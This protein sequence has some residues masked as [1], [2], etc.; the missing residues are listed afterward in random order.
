MTIPPAEAPVHA[1]WDDLPA[2]EPR[3]A[4][5]LDRDVEVCVVGAGLAGL[6][7]A[8]EAAR[9]GMSV[10]V[11]EGRRIGWA[12]SGCNLGSVLPGYGVPVND[13]IARVGVAHARELWM[14]AEAGGDYIRETIAQD[15]PEIAMVPG[16]LEVSTTDAGERLIRW[17]QIIGGEFG[18]EV[19]GWQIEHVREA[20]K[21]RRYFHALHFPRAFQ[22][23]SARYLRALAAL[24]EEA[25]AQI[26]EGTPVVSIDAAGIRKRI[27]T[28]SANLRA[29]HIVLAGNVH[30][31]TS[32]ERLATT[33]MPVWRYG[34]MTEPL[35]DLLHEAITYQG[36][37]HDDDGIDHFRVVGDRLLWASPETTWENK[38]ERFARAIR[39]RIATV[40]PQLAGVAIARTFASPFGQ[41]VHGMPQIGELRQGLWVA[42]GF[43]RQGLNTSAMAGRLIADGIVNGDDRWRLFSPFELV[44][45]GGRAGRI[46]GQFADGLTRSRSAAAGALARWR[47]RAAARELLREERR[48]ARIAAAQARTARAAQ[49]FDADR[50]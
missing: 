34:V 15:A 3:A 46:A 21:T 45:A 44:W 8:R 18:T 10:A 11:L 12:A 13:L 48:S 50:R 28:P 6:T 49:H 16:A 4:L 7:V 23:D 5:T 9:A 29:A 2:T 30:I 31:G 33:L 25:G 17:L 39:R 19:E 27:V 14:L 1:L 43:G 37:V 24:A 32:A 36:S 35:G 40:F 47:E 26:F 42:S 41:T 20:L 22:I 38:P